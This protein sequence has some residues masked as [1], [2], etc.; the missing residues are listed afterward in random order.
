LPAGLR[1]RPLHRLLSTDDPAFVLAEET[2]AGKGP[3]SSEVTQIA[4]NSAV[5]LAVE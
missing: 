4:P 3:L 2:M 5:I 1:D